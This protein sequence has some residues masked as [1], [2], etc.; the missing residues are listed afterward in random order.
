MGEK[1]EMIS[2]AYLSLSLG[3]AAQSAREGD[4]TKTAAY[5]ENIADVF[6]PLDGA[7]DP[8]WRAR[9]YICKYSCNTIRR[10]YEVYLIYTLT[11]FMT[12]RLIVF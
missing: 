4:F 1:L 12:S 7:D 11:L 2:N 8:V 9:R 3:L 6:F 10:K 5:I